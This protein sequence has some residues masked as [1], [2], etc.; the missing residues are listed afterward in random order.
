MVR[1]RHL[2]KG[3][4]AMAGANIKPKAEMGRGGKDK[5]LPTELG[6]SSEYLR[7]ARAVLRYSGDV[8][9]NVLTGAMTLTEAYKQ[10]QESKKSA[11]KDLDVA[12]RR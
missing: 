10:A 11:L 8:A 4:L 7:M 12:S 1:R 6:V 3:Q 9:E 2:T 5:N